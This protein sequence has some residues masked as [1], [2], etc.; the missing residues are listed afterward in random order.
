MDTKFM[1]ELIQSKKEMD[2]FYAKYLSTYVQNFVN[3]IKKC[4]L[5]NAKFGEYGVHIY[6]K[7]DHKDKNDDRGY[8][9][10]F[11]YAISDI[12]YKY[13]KIPQAFYDMVFIE[14][15]RQGLPTNG[16]KLNPLGLD[17]EMDFSSW[18]VEQKF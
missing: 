3:D 18:L 16:L 6:T 7:I 14:L 2:V 10:V 5:E 13:R 9:W 8:F 15:V 1:K 4:M 11:N 12:P 17:Y